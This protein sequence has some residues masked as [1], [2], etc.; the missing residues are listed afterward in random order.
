MKSVITAVAS[1]VVLSLCGGVALAQGP[2]GGGAQFWTNADANKDGAVT[3][4][5]FDA[6]RGARFTTQDANKDGFLV[7][8]EMAPP[9]GAG[10]PP[11]GG[12][13]GGGFGMRADADGDGK[14]SKAEYLAGGTMQWDRA[15]ANKDGKVDKAEI[16]SM[17]Q[18][19]PGGGRPGG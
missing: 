17:P 5:E 13:G 3:K 8:A 4:A 16:A 18:F 12:G 6:A 15:D 14:I 10:G 2:G 11:P 7:Q 9:P 1:V 19:G